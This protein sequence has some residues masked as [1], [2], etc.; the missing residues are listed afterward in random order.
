MVTIR[1]RTLP[2][3]HHLNYIQL[4]SLGLGV[5][6]C[7]EQYETF[8]SSLAWILLLVPRW[9][10]ILLRLMCAQGIAW[11]WKCIIWITFGLVLPRSFPNS[12]VQHHE[13]F[14]SLS[15][16]RFV[17]RGFQSQSLSRMQQPLT[18]V[19]ELLVYSVSLSLR[20][21][22]QEGEIVWGKPGRFRR[23]VTHTRPVP[24]WT[25]DHATVVV[26]MIPVKFHA[27]NNFTTDPDFRLRMLD[28]VLEANVQDM[29]LLVPVG[30]VP[31]QQYDN[32][33]FSLFIPFLSV[34]AFVALCG[35]IC[36][37]FLLLK[38]RSDVFPM[39]I[40]Q[41]SKEPC[42]ED[43][44]WVGWVGLC[45]N[46]WLLLRKFPSRFSYDVDFFFFFFTNRDI[47]LVVG[48]FRMMRRELLQFEWE[49]IDRRNFQRWQRL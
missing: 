15:L 26:E 42:H 38:S 9:L 3:A 8:W 22:D 11:H 35:I 25:P 17:L 7:H 13:F 5:A 24:A 16:S 47:Q 19:R 48:W 33:H 21:I 32:L 6:P 41:S 43:K 45:M 39:G 20:S 2:A 30:I 29:Q 23:D 18:P 37:L 14:L 1:H 31:V 46:E 28:D 12:D 49:V 10:M 27:T 4:I 34:A 44:A 36:F 40:V